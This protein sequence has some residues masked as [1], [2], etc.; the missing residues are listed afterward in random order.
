MVVINQ[1][2]DIPFLS[3]A[4][5]GAGICF[6]VTGMLPQRAIDRLKNWKR[7]VLRSMTNAKGN[8]D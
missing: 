8:A 1:F 2:A 7:A 6:L 5:A 3:G 4:L